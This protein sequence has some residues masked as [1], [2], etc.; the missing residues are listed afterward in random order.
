MVFACLLIQEP[1]L[2]LLNLCPVLEHWLGGQE[3]SSMDE[4]KT[5]E[6]TRAT[7]IK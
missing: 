3:N 2:G 7:L 5:E 4:F 1:A 6:K